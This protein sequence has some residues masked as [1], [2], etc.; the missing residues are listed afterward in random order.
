[1]NHESTRKKFNWTI[2]DYYQ[3]F[4]TISLERNNI[5]HFVNTLNNKIVTI[6]TKSQLSLE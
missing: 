6:A 4:G 5:A 3:S 2:I 1:M